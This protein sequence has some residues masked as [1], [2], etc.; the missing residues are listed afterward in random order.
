M[1]VQTIERRPNAGRATSTATPS[2]VLAGCPQW[3]RREMKDFRAAP[4][5]ASRW[6]EVPRDPSGDAPN[7]PVRFAMANVQRRK[8]PESLELHWPGR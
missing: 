1:Y 7:T 3:T 5:S 4:V 8:T 2:T 6:P